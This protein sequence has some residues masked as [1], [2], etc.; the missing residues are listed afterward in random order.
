MYSIDTSA[1][2]DGWVRYYPPDVFGS[3]WA[4]LKALGNAGTLFTPDEVIEELAKKEDG[5]CQWA[6]AELQVYAMDEE[7]QRVVSEILAA[8]ER[9]VDHRRSRSKCDPFVIALAKM[10]GYAVVTGEKASG[11]LQ[12]PKIPDVC[13]A[14]N[15]RCI[16]LLDLFREQGWSL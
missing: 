10:K 1:I 6:K 11:N 15:V 4:R 13:A 2:L 7:I 9:L 14:L 12:K 3:V 5:A 8:H 16:S